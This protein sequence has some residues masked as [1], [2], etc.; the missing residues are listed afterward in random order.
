[1]TSGSTTIISAQAGFAASGA[2]STEATEAQEAKLVAKK[3][4]RRTTD[5]IRPIFRLRF[6]D[7]SRVKLIFDT[8]KAYRA[9]LKDKM[10]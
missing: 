3:P 1:M 5:A 10:Y 8:F 9:W 6:G 2:A 7:G 4:P